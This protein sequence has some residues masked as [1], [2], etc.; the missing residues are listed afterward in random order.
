MEALVAVVGDVERSA[1]TSFRPEPNL[2]C[3]LYRVG[4]NPFAIQLCF[5]ARGYLVEAVDRRSA[6]ARYWSVVTPPG[7]ARTRVDRKA[8][9]RLIRLLGGDY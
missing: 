3:L 8:I 9:D 2:D 5:D 1:P 7:E 4:A 6:P